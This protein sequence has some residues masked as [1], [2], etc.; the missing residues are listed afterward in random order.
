[1]KGLGDAWWTQPT[2]AKAPD[3]GFAI[4]DCIFVCTKNG[5][6]G[7]NRRVGTEMLRSP[8]CVRYGRMLLIE[9]VMGV[10]SAKGGV[11]EGM[12]L[13][14]TGQWSQSFD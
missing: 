9:G 7:T 6:E 2:R 12:W 11:V 4:D 5:K 10:V 1:L 14:K 3:V 8:R 13:E